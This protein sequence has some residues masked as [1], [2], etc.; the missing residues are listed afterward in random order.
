MGTAHHRIR[1][2]PTRSRAWD[3][4]SAGPHDVLIVG[5]GIT[6]CG[7]AR[8]AARRG[9]KTVLVEMNDLAFGTSSR[10]SKLVHGG[11]RYLEQY[12]FSLVFESVSERRVLM[13]IAPH[14]VNPLG[15][16]FPV[17]KGSRVGLWK[18]NAGMWLYDGLSLF[19]SP[20]LHRKLKPADVKKEEPAL[21]LDGLTGAPLFYD[22]Q[23]DDARLTL[24]TALD[25]VKAGAMV[26]TWAKVERFVLEKGR[27]RGAVVRD[28]WTGE[29]KTI[30]AH[31][32]VNATGP[33]TDRTLALAGHA[34]APLLRP[35]KGVHIVV[36]RPTLPLNNAIVATHPVDGRVLFLLPWGDVTYLGTT[37]TDEE[38][39][40]ADVRASRADVDYLIAAA[41]AYCPAHPIRHDDVIATWAGLRPLI[42]PVTGETV[43]ESSVS[44]EHRLVVGQDG[45]VTIAG[46]KLTTYRRMAGEIVDTV[47]SLLRLE[48]KVAA[49]LAPARTDTEPL[50]GGIGWP[51]DDDHAEVGRAVAAAGAGRLDAA[52]SRFLGDTYGMR[53]IDLARTVA[54]KPELAEPLVRGR[55]EVLG[56]VDWAVE[57]ELAATI[58]DVLVRRTQLYYRDREQG[59][60]AA[61]MVGRRMAELIG[62]SEHRL[63]AEL[64]AYDAEV[65]RSRRWRGE[66]G[67]GPESR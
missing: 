29:E 25:A 6:G 24:E 18:I 48:G 38:V 15:F 51:D 23:T 46:G 5:G 53:A 43:D 60:M 2:M 8:D 56:Q 52:R 17:Y 3:D 40:P 4:L 13:D 49:E 11:L 32:V 20:K 21:G 26:A 1:V 16:L 30:R 14:L 58:A 55:P 33:W 37:D 12:E 19:R 57:E 36:P 35:T 34:S 41:R 61:P 64:S 27:I 54:A 65:A 10:S 59:L 50:P 67:S 44:R 22:C 31:V 47:V 28:A 9:L 42:A 39:D 63:A 45:L 7:V 66:A 62:W